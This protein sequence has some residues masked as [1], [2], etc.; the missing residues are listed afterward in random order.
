MVFTTQVTIERPRQRV[1]DLIRNPDN[2]PKWQPGLVSV[3]LISGEKDQVGS[4]SRVIYEMRG[5]RLSVT[6]TVIKHS[7]PDVFVSAY[8]SRGVKNISENRFFEEGPDASRWVLI[9]DFKFT[10]L[11]S[12]MGVFFKDMVPKQ[13]LESM[14]RFKE[15]AESS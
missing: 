10:G 12:V 11:M 8:E 9:N 5:I 15:F 7:P 2:F 14:N 1:L 3:E 6:E 4:K 13:T